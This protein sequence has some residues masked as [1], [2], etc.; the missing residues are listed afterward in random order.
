M[1]KIGKRVYLGARVT[2]AIEKWFNRIYLPIFEEPREEARTRDRTI[3]QDAHGAMSPSGSI[4]PNTARVLRRRMSVAPR[5]RQ[6]AT[7]VRRVVKGHFET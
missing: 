4:A 6:L 5:K 3:L 1:C 7:K 2:T